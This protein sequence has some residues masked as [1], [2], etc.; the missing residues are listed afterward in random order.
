MISLHYKIYTKNDD[1]K[2]GVLYLP[3]EIIHLCLKEQDRNYI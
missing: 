2:L 3:K 1:K